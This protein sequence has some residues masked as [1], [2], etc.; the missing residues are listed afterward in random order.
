MRDVPVGSIGNAGQSVVPGQ[1]GGQDTED[2]AGDGQA[3]VGVPRSI[4]LEVGDAEAEEGEV[5]GEEEGKE[6]HRRFHGA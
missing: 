5:K 1:E 2:A 4:G 3:F 6:C